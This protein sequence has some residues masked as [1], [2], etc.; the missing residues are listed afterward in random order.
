MRKDT[1]SQFTELRK[2][3][4]VFVAVAVGGSKLASHQPSQDFVIPYLCYIFQHITLRLD[5][6]FFLTVLMHDLL[7]SWS[8][9]TLLLQLDV[10]LSIII[11]FSRAKSLTFQFD[12]LSKGLYTRE[13]LWT[14][15]RSFSLL[16]SP[17]FIPDS[18]FM[19]LLFIVGSKSQS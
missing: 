5:M 14:F 13:Q 2:T 11:I 9:H 4:V 1:A 16:P 10:L 7:P 18:L 19:F 15:H 6:Q 3:T 8:Q 17:L 12:Q